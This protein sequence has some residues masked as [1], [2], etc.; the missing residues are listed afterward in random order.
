[1]AV[2]GLPIAPKVA[3]EMMRACGHNYINHKLLVFNILTLR[4]HGRP[5]ERQGIPGVHQ[6][7]DRKVWLL[8]NPA[9]IPADGGGG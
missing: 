1:M 2:L 7:K 6:P 9:L 8:A 5:T 3:D 4:R